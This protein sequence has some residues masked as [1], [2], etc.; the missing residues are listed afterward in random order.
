MANLNGKLYSLETLDDG[1]DHVICLFQFI[2]G[3]IF[4]E[5]LTSE[6]LIY[7]SGEYL[8]KLTKILKVLR[9]PFKSDKTGVKLIFV[10]YRISTIVL[11][12]NIKI[13]G[14]Y[15]LFQN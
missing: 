1:N 13:P 15:K 8:A 14:N 11:T 12:M 6:H 4:C 10:F 7:Q 9:M 2:P 5:I 3:K